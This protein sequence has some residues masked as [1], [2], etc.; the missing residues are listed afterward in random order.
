MIFGVL[1]G[2]ALGLGNY[3]VVKNL[4]LRL[5]KPG[6]HKLGLSLLFVLK[7]L[8]LLG[9]VAMCFSIFQVNV[10]AFVIGYACTLL[11]PV[12]MALRAS[13]EPQAVIKE[14]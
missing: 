7:M 4:V 2:L 12:L 14:S 3:F 13:L 9:L 1:I 5:V 10:L 6:T 11:V 8:C